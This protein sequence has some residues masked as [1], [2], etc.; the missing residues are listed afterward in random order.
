MFCAGASDGLRPE[1][2]REIDAAN[3]QVKTALAACVKG[4]AVPCASAS[5][6]AAPELRLQLQRGAACRRRPSNCARRRLRRRA[7]EPEQR[8]QGAARIRRH[9]RIEVRSLCPIA[10]V[11]AVDRRHSRLRSHRR[12]ALELRRVEIDDSARIGAIARSAFLSRVSVSLRRAGPLAAPIASS[13]VTTDGAN[14]S[15]SAVS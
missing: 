10:D 5:S 12:H 11:D 4:S 13:R 9:L 15:I 7:I 8:Q 1:Q 14:G 3:P 6:P 2:R